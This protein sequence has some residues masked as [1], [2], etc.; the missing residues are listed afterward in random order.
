[1]H[2]IDSP[3]FPPTTNPPQGRQWDPIQRQWVRYSLAEEAARVAKDEEAYQKQQQQAAE[4]QQQ[5][6]KVGGGGGRR[7]K[8]TALY[9]L[10]ELQPEASPEEI[11][12]AYYKVGIFIQ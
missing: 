6:G 5:G 10:L 12:K 8:E 7:V 4:Q 2:L 11:K 3:L 1:M 9:D